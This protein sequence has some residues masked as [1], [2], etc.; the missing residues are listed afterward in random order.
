MK[1]QEALGKWLR[2]WGRGVAPKTKALVK[3]W[4]E[5]WCAFWG[6]DTPLRRVS[7]E[8]V[9]RL[10]LHRDNGER[11]ASALN[12]EK[13]YLGEFMMWCALH[14]YRDGDP[15]DV[16]PTRRIVV[17]RQ[18]VFLSREEER[19]LWEAAR[20]P[21]LKRYIVWGICTGLRQ[22]TIRQAVSDWLVPGSPTLDYWL[23]VPAYAMKAGQGISLLLPERAIVAIERPDSFPFTKGEG[24]LENRRGRLALV[25][26]RSLVPLPRVEYVWKR[27]K[28][29]VKRAGINPATSPH[30]LRRTFSFRL[31]QAGIPVERIRQMG[32]WGSAKAFERAYFW[33]G[34]EAEARRIAEV[35]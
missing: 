6:G 33:P 19:A 26:G 16:W 21:W 25:P 7:I 13:Y 14:Q 24:A 5:G 29:A 35:L 20:E 11:S 18:Y 23:V 28:K 12:S 8:A 4:G 10:Y 9:E 27:F 31:G 17:Q 30:D 3:R 2:V 32:G 1:L 15:T 22:G 34:G